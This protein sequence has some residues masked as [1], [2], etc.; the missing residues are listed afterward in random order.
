LDEVFVSI[1]AEQGTDTLRAPYPQVADTQTGLG[2]T[3]GMLAAHAF[4]PQAA[5]LVVACDMPLLNRALLETLIAGRNP[6]RGATAFAGNDELPE[7]LCA[8]YEP[9]T[10]AA[11]QAAIAGGAK[12]AGPRSLLMNTDIA[13]LKHPAGRIDS[14]NTPDELALLGADSGAVRP[15]D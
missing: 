11:L 6:L 15:N 2:P 13:L 8:I 9:A 5:W 14:F 1:R 7:P 4:D 3:G 12:V 10:L